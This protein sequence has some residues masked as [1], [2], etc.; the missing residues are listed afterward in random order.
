MGL[1]VV[2]AGRGRPST[3]RHVERAFWQQVAGGLGTEA[4]AAAVGVSRTMA[5]RWFHDGGG[6]PTLELTE[7]TGRY[8]SMAER[9]E[10]A[11]WQGHKV[12]VR[13]MARRV[14]RSPAAA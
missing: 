7:P 13:E 14:K 9:E 4:A 5:H 3:P 2:M 11:I 6:M 12:G 8:L 1:G 10:I